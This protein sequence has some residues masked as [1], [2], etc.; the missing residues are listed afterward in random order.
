MRAA[1]NKPWMSLQSSRQR[2]G[3]PD[4]ARAICR[5]SLH[6]P[7]RPE[8]RP[9]PGLL[10]Q[11]KRLPHSNRHG[12]PAGARR[13]GQAQ[14]NGCRPPAATVFQPDTLH[15]HPDRDRHSRE[16]RCPGPHS[17]RAN[18]RWL[19]SNTGIAGNSGKGRLAARLAGMV[20]LGPGPVGL[21]RFPG[22]GASH[23]RVRLSLSLCLYSRRAYP[24]IQQNQS[25]HV[26]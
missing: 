7:P 5:L 15:A 26:Y 11:P 2:P 18:T 22:P 17:P 21:R 10:R 6:H 12:N 24:L 13:S 4:P 16:A 14:K 19:L 25:S 23:S 1:R 20:W 3:L 9:P 8:P